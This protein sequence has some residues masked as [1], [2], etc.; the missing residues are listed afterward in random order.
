MQEWEALRREARQLE[1]RLEVSKAF[2]EH[3]WCCLSLLGMGVVAGFVFEKWKRRV[4]G[5]IYCFLHGEDVTICIV[6]KCK[7]RVANQLNCYRYQCFSVCYCVVSFSS[8]KGSSL[9]QNQ[10]TYD[11]ITR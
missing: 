10:R 4:F 5:F 8:G 11:C 6:T 1:G 3:L 9:C 7:A 2:E